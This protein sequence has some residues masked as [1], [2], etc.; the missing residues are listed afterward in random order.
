SDQFAL[1]TLIA[2]SLPVSH[3]L[4]V[5]IHP[6]DVD[7]RSLSWFRR[8]AAIPGVR[9]IN[10]DVSSRALVERASIVF[11][12]TG[13]IGYEAALLGKTVITFAKNFYNGLPTVRYCDTPTGLPSLIAASL[14]HHPTA[15]LDERAIEFL[16][17]LK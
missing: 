9:L 12:L 6:T 14:E 7:G 2:R 8:I 16:T 5:K 11:T 1:I 15:D 4:Y 3:D 17:E 10:Y 13:T